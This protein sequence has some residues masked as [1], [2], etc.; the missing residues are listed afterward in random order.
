MD[1]QLNQSVYEAVYALIRSALWAQPLDFAKTPDWE[2]VYREME[3]HT[4]TGLCYEIADQLPKEV[5]LEL[6]QRWKKAA[7][8]EMLVFFRVMYGQEALVKLFTSNEIPIAIL[9]GAAAAQYYPHPE[10]RSMGDVD[11]IVPREKAERALSLMLEN[12]YRL[13]EEAHDSSLHDILEKDGVLFE[14]H[15]AFGFYQSKEQALEMDE[16]LSRGFQDIRFISCD[17][18]LVPVFP[19]LLNGLILLEHAAKHFYSGFGLRQVV[20][21]MLFVY[22]YHRDQG[23]IEDFLLE[24]EQ[25][26]L[27]TFA[28]T[29]IGISQK[30][31]GLPKSVLSP[32]LVD[33]GVCD[34]LTEYIM[35]HGNF[36]VKNK[37]EGAKV[38]GLLTQ[39]KS[40]G[41]WF[42]HLQDSG[43]RH[44]PFQERFPLW[45][46]L[47][48]VYG[49]FR[50]LRL[51]LG[52]QNAFSKLLG[53]YRQSRQNQSLLSDLGIEKLHDSAQL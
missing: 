23:Q 15:R 1:H 34:R 16:R 5:D 38:E 25:I 44:W 12:G 32:S 9:K 40:L 6:K 17:Q 49:A 29:L 43:L 19:P 42:K 30:H 4:L 45:R 48:W 47:G 20:D 37:T 36:G 31:L 8:R 24:A 52:R 51:A 46:P 13:L 10:W 41:G 11:L 27:R 14:L 2:L 26:G 35:D 33:E 53:E 39:R 7:Q 21:V 22:A 3:L 50:Y 18:S 28:Q